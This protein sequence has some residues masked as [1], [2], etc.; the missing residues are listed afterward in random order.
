MPRSRRWEPP[1]REIGLPGGGDEAAGGA[2]LRGHAGGVG[3]H[4]RRARAG[5]VSA[6]A[7][8]TR[9]SDPPPPRGK[10]LPKPTNPSLPVAGRGHLGER[11]PAAGHLPLRRARRTPDRGRHRARLVGH[12]AS[13]AG[14]SSSA[15][16]C[17]A[18]TWGCPAPPA[19]TSTSPCSTRCREQVYQPLSH[20]SRQLFNHCLCTPPWVIQQDLRIGETRLMQIAYPALPAALAY[21]DVS[22]ATLAPFVHVPVSPVGT[23]PVARQPTNLAR[24]PTAGPRPAHSRSSSATPTSRRARQSIQIDRVVAAPGRTSV[25]WTL[26]SVSDQNTSRLRPYGPPVSSPPPERCLRAEQQP[27]QR[28]SDQPD[29]APR[30]RALADALGRHGDLRQPAYECLCTELGSVVLRPP[31]RGRR[32]PAH[33]Q[34]PGA[35]GR[36]PRGRHRAAGLRHLPQGAGGRGRRTRRR[37]C[38]R[39]SPRPPGSGPTGRG[40]APRA[41]RPPTGRPTCPIPPSSATYRLD[42]RDGHR[43]SPAAR[44]D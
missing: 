30:P 34:L 17:P 15:T 44:A 3:L 36:H 25:Q 4:L 23:A 19:A 9:P 26:R 6:P 31:G 40:S 5:P 11:W 12:P 29:H 2:G 39:P 24:S 16:T 33:R 22:L 1:R 28:A 37:P 8:P 38:C 10:F 41:G 27:G 42:R 35:A 13:G 7:V 18:S 21:V 43:C 32:R 20:E 14:A